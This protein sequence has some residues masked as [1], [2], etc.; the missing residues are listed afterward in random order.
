[1]RQLNLVDQFFFLNDPYELTGISKL[2]RFQEFLDIKQELLEEQ[3]ILKQGQINE[4]QMNIKSSAIKVSGKKQ[5]KRKNYSP[6]KHETL[7]TEENEELININNTK[8]MKKLEN[9][10]PKN[11]EPI[12]KKDRTQVSVHKT[13]LTYKFY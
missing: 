7:H 10:I 1:M 6:N 3:K 8:N 12:N 2:K 9:S 4:T 5:E 11:A 13:L